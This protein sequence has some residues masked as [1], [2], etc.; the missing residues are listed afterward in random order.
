MFICMLAIYFEYYF[1]SKMTEKKILANMIILMKI[2][3]YVKK[4]LSLSLSTVFAVI[5]IN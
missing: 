1:A 2:K 5:N 3:V 4:K